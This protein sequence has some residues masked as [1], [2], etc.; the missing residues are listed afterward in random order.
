MTTTTTGWQR[1]GIPLRI[2][3]YDAADRMVD[4]DGDGHVNYCEYKW[5]TTQGTLVVPRS[6]QLCDL[7]A[8]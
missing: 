8:E 3:P 4:T 1:L 2:R 7:F 6:G 5:D